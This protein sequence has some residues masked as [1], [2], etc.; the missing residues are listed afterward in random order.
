MLNMNVVFKDEET[1]ITYD[2]YGR[3]NYNPMFHENN[4][5]PWDPEDDEYIIN[6]YDI[7]GPEEMSFAISRTIKSAMNRVARLRKAGKMRKPLK[8]VSTKRI[9]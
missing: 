8:S 9:K 3:M 2:R 5:K 6:W 4:R 1:P 7:I